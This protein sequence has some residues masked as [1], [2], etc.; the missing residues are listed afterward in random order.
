LIDVG[1]TV[2]ELF[3]LKTPPWHKG[4]SLL[5]RA[6]DFERTFPL[7]A[8]GRLRRAYFDRVTNL[9]VIESLRINTTEVYDLKTDPGE[10]NNLFGESP[11]AEQAVAR[12][13]AFFSSIEKPWFPYKR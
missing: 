12:S 11:R 9:K 1:P 8:E 4:D 13:R 3:G 7:A 6:N 5:G 2:L 10:L